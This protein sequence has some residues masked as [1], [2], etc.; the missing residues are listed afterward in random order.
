MGYVIYVRGWGG[1]GGGLEFKLGSFVLHRG[2]VLGGVLDVLDCLCNRIRSGWE[3]NR[4][5]FCGEG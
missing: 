3:I 5:V 1:G 2:G 4:R